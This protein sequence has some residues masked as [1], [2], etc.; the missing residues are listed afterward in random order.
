MHTGVYGTG[1]AH[2]A[3]YI[4][5]D[6]CVYVVSMVTEQQTSPAPHSTEYSVKKMEALCSWVAAALIIVAALMP[7]VGEFCAH[8]RS[9]LPC[10]IPSPL[11]APRDICH[12]KS[13]MM[14]GQ[15]CYRYVQSAA[16]YSAA[17]RTCVRDGRGATLL[18]I[19]SEEESM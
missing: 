14:N 11:S 10:L 4:C 9:L 2:G 12:D 17:N 3:R 1:M 18:F 7:P 13:Y 6:V 16:D 8:A 5:S 19:D 15:Y